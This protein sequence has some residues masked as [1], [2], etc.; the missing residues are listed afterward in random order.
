MQ[1][2]YELVY[3]H[4]LLLKSHNIKLLKYKS[5]KLFI[6]GAFFLF[7]FIFRVIRSAVNE[8]RT[9]NTMTKRKKTQKIIIHDVMQNT[10]RL[11]VCS[12]I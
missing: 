7:Y 2:D 3:L 9:D 10:R 11:R 1:Y 12:C 8:R 4:Y 6:K 5:C